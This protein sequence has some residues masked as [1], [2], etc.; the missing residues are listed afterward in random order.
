MYRT[1]GRTVYQKG[2]KYDKRTTGK[3][4]IHLAENMRHKKILITEG[5][6]YFIFK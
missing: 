4:K 3:M 6:F 5:R 1:T 2:K